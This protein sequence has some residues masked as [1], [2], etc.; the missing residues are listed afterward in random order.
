MSSTVTCPSCGHQFSPDDVLTHEIEAELRGKL[1]KELLLKAKVEA[2]KELADREIQIKE[3]QAKAK[4]SEENEL[5]LRAEKRALLES[6]EKF[7][8]EK[9]RQLD[10]ERG[11]IKADAEKAILEKQKYKIDEY[12]KKLRDMQKSLE[13]AQRKGSQGSQQLQGEVLELEI[14]DILRRSF[15]T[16]QI[17]PIAKGVNGAD[18]RQIVRGRSGAIAGTIIWE[19]KRAK[20]WI[21]GWIQKLKDD[22]RAE[23]SE[24]AVLVTTVLPKEIK[25]F[26]VHHGIWVSDTGSM[27][28]LALALR[29]SILQVASVKQS[30]VGKNE[31]MEV[32]YNYLSGIEFQQRI[33]VIVESFTTM[34]QDLEKEKL[35]YTKIWAKRDKQIEQVVHNTI[36]LHSDLEGLMGKALPKIDLLELPGNS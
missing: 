3:L 1:E 36:G 22:Q 10:E 29:L 33:E 11:K 4:E 21:E 28:G 8:L 13:D 27:I 18:I 35:A 7:E 26:G 23:K 34:K 24:A 25:T 2:G 6:K 31:K 17:E 30:S 32:L 16:D 5:K 14:E 15:P 19:T 20:N 12:E 9:Q